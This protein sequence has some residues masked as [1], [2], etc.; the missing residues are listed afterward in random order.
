MANTL[1]TN[2]LTSIPPRPRRHPAGSP[3]STTSAASEA[4]PTFQLI[5]AI[6][7]GTYF[8]ALLGTIFH[9]SHPRIPLS[10]GW[11]PYFLGVVTSRPF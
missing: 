9:G 8:P 7:F 2:S 1:I 11:L 6:Y 4:K 10:H 5:P 3:R